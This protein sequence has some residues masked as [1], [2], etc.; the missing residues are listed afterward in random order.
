MSVIRPKPPADPISYAPGCQLAAGA[1]GG[2]DGGEAALDRARRDVQDDAACRQPEQLLAA[3]NT[4]GGRRTSELFAILQAARHVRDAIDRVVIPGDDLGTLGGRAVFE[5][6]AHPRHNDLSRGD[7]GGRPRLLY[8]GAALGNDGLQAILDLV[9][10]CGGRSADDLL[11]A[12]GVLAVGSGSANGF[13]ATATR[14]LCERLADGTL[15]AERLRERACFVAAAGDWLADQ[16][17]ACDCRVRFDAL[18]GLGAAAVFSAAGLL[19]ASIAGIDVVRLLE[20]AA[21]LLRRFREAPVAENPVLR[22]VAAIRGAAAA[23]GGGDVAC[24]L[25]A[26]V[27]QLAAACAWHDRLDAERRRGGRKSAPVPGQG[28]PQAVERCL[29]VR[30]TV[31]APRREPLPL[32]GPPAF[33]GAAP[34]ITL[35]RVDEHAIGQLLALF[36]VADRMLRRLGD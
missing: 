25:V 13:A 16:A 22:H 20:G 3:Y 21:A 2:H 5:S 27:D 6:C 19:P 36:I 10:P 7:R 32:P 31:D 28:E 18:P 30:V 9:A 29:V 35:P 1:M 23:V 34:V 15:G 14:L 26:A 17:A 24:R 12:W 11:D 4:G 8:A 33:P